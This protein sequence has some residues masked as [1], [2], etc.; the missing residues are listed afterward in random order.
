[1]SHK[2]YI[3]QLASIERL[4]A[5]IHQIRMRHKA[6]NLADPVP[7]KPDECYV[8]GQSQNSPEDLT[9]FM[10]SNVGDPAVEVSLLV[11]VI[12][13]LNLIMQPATSTSL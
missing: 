3:S 7:N 9:S 5:R 10:Q 4:Q 12:I 8:I 1:M 6:L 2:A 11:I 13:L